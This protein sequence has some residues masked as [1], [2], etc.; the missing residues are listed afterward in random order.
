MSLV[1][2]TYGAAIV[3]MLAGIM[4][5]F[6]QGESQ[7]AL[8]ERQVTA[9]IQLAKR[10]NRASQCDPVG[11]QYSI[12]ELATLAGVQ[13]G[14]VSSEYGWQIHRRTARTIQIS[15]QDA[16]QDILLAMDAQ[17]A[18]ITGTNAVLVIGQPARIQGSRAS[19][20]RTQ[21]GHC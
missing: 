20:L 3:V 12:N 1:D 21:Q 8:A 15:I 17:N 2:L 9:V 10:A 13:P 5:G 6:W 18:Q 7:A 4:L 19:F 14:V 16:P 11:R